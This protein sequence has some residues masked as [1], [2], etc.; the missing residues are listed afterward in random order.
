ME[1]KK[2]NADFRPG[3]TCPPAASHQTGSRKPLVLWPDLPPAPATPSHCPRALSPLPAG[4][5][6]TGRESGDHPL[7]RSLITP[8]PAPDVGGSPA[9]PGVQTY[10]YLQD[11]GLP[12]GL[13]R[14]LAQSGRPA[15]LVVAEPAG[16]RPPGCSL[17]AGGASPELLTLGWTR[18]G[19]ATPSPGWPPTS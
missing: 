2:K 3:R 16:S 15:R 17:R 13:S 6:P 1:R 11:W 18:L 4:G 12:G 10:V 5:G 9:P 14:P 8:V 7:E 19:G